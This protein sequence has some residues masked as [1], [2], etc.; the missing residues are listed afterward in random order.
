MPASKL[1]Q[2]LRLRREKGWLAVLSSRALRVDD[3]LLEHYNWCEGRA[4]PGYETLCRDT[5]QCRDTVAEALRELEFYRRW[6]IHRA[7]RRPNEYRLPPEVVPDVPA[8][9]YVPSARWTRRDR[10]V[11]LRNGGA[12]SQSR[13]SRG[14]ESRASHLLQSRVSRQLQSRALDRNYAVNYALNNAEELRSGNG[15]FQSPQKVKG[16]V[17]RH[18]EFWRS[19]GGGE[20]SFPSVRLALAA[21]LRCSEGKA[22]DLLRDS[23]DEQ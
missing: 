16:T 14:V 7:P 11:G 18:R 17:E 23:G 15:G 1:Y 4:W 13:A 21:A 6:E 19:I 10:L 8:A 22:G 5:G 3:V 2:V 20:E 12:R 9:R